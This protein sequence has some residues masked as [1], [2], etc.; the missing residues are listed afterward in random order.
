MNASSL[1]LA[2]ALFFP[3]FGASAQTLVAVPDEQ[4]LVGFYL[5]ARLPGLPRPPALAAFLTLA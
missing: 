3:F 4:E 2:A 1:F 5:P